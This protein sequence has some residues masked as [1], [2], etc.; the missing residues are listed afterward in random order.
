M[1]DSIHLNDHWHADSKTFALLIAVLLTGCMTKPPTSFPP[2]TAIGPYAQPHG[3]II[4][5]GNHRAQLL[6]NC[7]KS[8][9][10]GACRFTHGASGRIMELRWQRQQIWQRSNSADQQQWQQLPVNS[11]YKL[12][13]V[14]HPAV[15]MDLLNNTIPPWLHPKATNKWQGKQHNNRIQ[16]AW[17]PNRNRLEITN[18]T[19]GSKIKLLLEPTSSFAIDSLEKP[20]AP[21]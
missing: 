4:L 18:L 3:R 7:Q 10:G 12:G 1:S 2:S 5:L 13:L 17:F 15:M 16:M 9:D 11:L 8:T 19:K 14:V 21:Q 6:F 20:I